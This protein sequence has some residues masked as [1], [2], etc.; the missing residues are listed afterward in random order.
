AQPNEQLAATFARSDYPPELFVVMLT[1]EGRIKKLS[2]SE[3]ANLTGRGLMML[4]LGDEDT[5][6]QVALATQ[7]SF[8]VVAT[9]AG[10]LLRFV[11]NETQLP[12]MS[13]TAVGLQ[14]LKLRKG[15]SIIGMAVVAETD[16]LLLASRN[17]LLKRLKVSD[18]RLQ[19]RGGLA[20]PVTVLG[21][22]T[23]TLIA[24]LGSL[25]SERTALST[26]SQERLLR[27]NFAGVSLRSRTEPAERLEALE[28]G[29]KLVGM[30]W[31]IDGESEA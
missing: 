30:T 1:R 24:L 25:G 21:D 9:S 15:E 13:R 31:A 7:E 16:F 17:G 5:L 18:L 14:A 3:C 26:T 19:E 27:L 4:K 10:R 2:L 11:C 8:V 29:E 12:V 23:D 6:L 20:T 22:R 28:T